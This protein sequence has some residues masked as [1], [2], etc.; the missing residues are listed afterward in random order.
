M[1]NRPVTC[2]WQDD[3]RKDTSEFIAAYVSD[4]EPSLTATRTKSRPLDRL[5]LVG[6]G[7]GE[8][9][10]PHFVQIERPGSWVGLEVSHSLDGILRVRRVLPDGL[11]DKWNASNPGAE[12]RP[13]GFILELGGKPTTFMTL[14]EITAYFSQEDPVQMLVS[15]H[16]ATP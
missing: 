10:D 9:A 2:C 11:V 15:D 1:G 6:E 13:G 7:A 8:N 14:M 16:A 12:V 4:V 3:D 5:P